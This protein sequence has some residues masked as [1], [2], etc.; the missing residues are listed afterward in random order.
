MIRRHF[1]PVTLSQLLDI[2]RSGGKAAPN[3]IVL[4]VDDGYRDFHDVAWPL[5]KRHDVP[6]TLF[7]T[8]GFVDGELWLW[9][10]QLA[11]LLE[12]V[13][14]LPEQVVAPPVQLQRQPG[15]VWNRSTVW[16]ALVNALLRLPDGEKHSAIAALAA[17]LGTRLPAAPPSEYAAV[18]WDQLRQMQLAGLDVGGH[19]HSHP[20]LPRVADADLRLEIDHCRERLDAELG[21]RPRPFCYPNGQPADF[22]QAVRDRVEKAGFT[23][24]VVAYADGQPHHDL[25]ALRRH[26]AAD[27]DFQYSKALSGLEWLGQR[28]RRMVAA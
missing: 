23:G 28:V 22:S 8:T 5:L 11:W 19:T 6:A 12:S 13:Q 27:S 2:W 15:K 25:Y 24:A 16:Q 7:V 3:T 9:P 1:N 14:T 18:S 4:T 10:D 26:A 20:T 17:G 21:P